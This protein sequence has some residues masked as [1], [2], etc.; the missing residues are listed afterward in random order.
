MGGMHRRP[1]T[2]LGLALGLAVALAVAGCGGDEEAAPSTSPTTATAATTATAVEAV[3][4]SEDEKA[5]V[6]K[7]YADHWPVFDAFLSGRP[8]GDPADYFAGARLADLPRSVTD[9]AQKGLEIQGQATLDPGPVTITGN[10]AS[11]TD[12]HLDST[13]AVAKATGEVVIE[14][15]TAPQEVEVELLKSGGVW[16]V[17]SVVYGDQSCVQVRVRPR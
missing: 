11:F 6:L 7:A 17:S 12:C 13:T 9:F 3:I 15:A 8:P 1:R 14:P 10:K 4:P 16:K 5:A 2:L